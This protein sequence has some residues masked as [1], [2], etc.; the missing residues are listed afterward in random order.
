MKHR[1]RA[2]HPL[3]NRPIEHIVRPFQDF[4]H[5]EASSGIVLLLAAV[6]ALIW[7]NSPWSD[8][9]YEL[10][11]THLRIGFGGFL[12]D[13]PLEAWI[14]DALIVVFFFVVGLEIKRSI[15]VGELSS[16]KSAVLPVVAAL[17]GV[18]LPAL[19]Y[20]GFNTLGSEGGRG[21]AIPVA[22][23]IAFS[24]GVLAL[25]GSRV[26]LS[27]KMFLV[28][29][30]IADDIAGVTI[31]AVFYTESISWMNLGVA[32]GFLG[33]LIV[34]NRLDI[35]N[36]LPYAVL[37]ILVWY[38]FLQSGV[39]TTVAGI[40]VAATVPI[41]VRMD[42]DRF[43]ER[44]RILLAEFERHDEDATDLLPATNEQR[45]AVQELEVACQ[46]VG[47][48]LQRM[49]HAIHPWVAFLIIP[50]F[51]LANAGVALDTGLETALTSSIT[52]GVLV[53]L[54]AGKSV[55]V[56]LFAWLAVRSGVAAMPQGVNWRQ[57][58][59][60]AL[61]GGIGFTMALFITNLTFV[62]N[63]LIAN[64]KIGI[65]AGSIIAGAGG[66]LI[67]RRASSE[68]VADTATD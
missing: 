49:E 7:V 27:L 67:L 19:I 25:L 29:F 43:L 53:G 16:P 31:I 45:A 1:S 35:H 58:F 44:A 22:T 60:V 57:M 40:L 39:H 46:R 36:P 47:S 13:K 50:I 34:A 12:L 6:A 32:F 18:I 9:Y 42:A 33:A 65:L 8:S 23:D 59:G 4:A 24:L 26:P 56:T 52:W 55:G 5:Q 15:L 41:R 54:V 20:L 62:D 38:Y 30:A 2:A 64:A 28:A 17:G 21:W 11:E 3:E 63:G 14:N 66:W 48:P 10:W 51:A 37:G 68:R 61:L